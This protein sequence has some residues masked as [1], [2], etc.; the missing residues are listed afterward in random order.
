MSTVLVGNLVADPAITVVGS[1]TSERRCR[2]QDPHSDYAQA[3]QVSRF[4]RLVSV[5]EENE[6][7][8]WT[9]DTDRN[10]YGVFCLDGRRRPAHEL[11]LSFTTGEKRHPSL[12]TCHSCDNPP[13]CNPNHLRFDTRRSNVGDMVQRG[14]AATPNR[15][16]TDEQIII[17]RERRALG[18][19]QKDLAHQFGISDGQVSTIVRGI[20]WRHIGGPIQTK[21]KYSRGK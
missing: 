9:G 3:V 13:C 6:C 10:G 2:A 17:I 7:W 5:A 8:K 12:D 1:L 20:Q 11:A 18:A 14:R 21:R 4:W 16:L 15:K 19:R